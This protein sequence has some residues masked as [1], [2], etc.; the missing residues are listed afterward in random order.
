LERIAVLSIKDFKY[1][2]EKQID[3]KNRNV[4]RKAE[5]KGVVVRP[6]EFTDD[7]VRG[8]V[9]IYN[10][11]PV[12]QGKPF[13]HYGKDFDTIKAANGTNLERSDF[14]GAYFD[15]ELIGFAKLVY[16]P[17]SARAE[18]ILSKIEHRDKS[19]TNALIAKAVEVCYGKGVP[20]LLYGHW[21]SGTL[22]DF[23]QNNGFKEMSIPRYY[24]PLNGKGRLALKCNLHKEVRGLV[25]DRVTTWV[26]GMRRRWYAGKVK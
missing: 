13:W 2:W 10:E 21:S 14:L 23:K 24:V 4:I 17:R 11:T 25:P 12:R 3:S 15:G 1:W 22:T 6:A 7:F 20:Y 18:Q 8:I 19:P 26:R 16:G 9:D 5:K